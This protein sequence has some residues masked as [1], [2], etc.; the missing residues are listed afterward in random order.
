MTPILLLA[1]MLAQPAAKPLFNGKDLEGWARVNCAPGTFYVKDNQIITTGR[2]TGYLRSDKHYENFV[3]EFEWMHTK[4]SGVANSGMFVWGDA[5]PA[6]GVGY[7]RSIEV[8]VLCG[9]EDNFA[10]NNPGKRSWASDHGDLFSIW[11]AHCTP[12]RPHPDKIERCNPSENRSKGAGEWNHYKIT[13][14]DGVLKL[15]VNGKEV[16][17]VSKCTPRKGYIALES[18]GSECI[19]RNF[20]MEE[21]PSTNPKPEEIC[22]LAQGHETL[23]DGMTLD[24]WDAADGTW[25]SGDGSMKCVKDGVLKT[26]AALPAGEL[27]FDW[28]VGKEAKPEIM[29]TCGAET[30]KIATTAKGAGGY[31]RAQ[32]AIPAGTLAFPAL[33]DLELRSIFFKP[34]K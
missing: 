6:V 22:T 1:A 18:E 8:Q 4:K 28:K 13:A 30:V 31:C 24:G 23:F 10:K 15:A 20:K 17:G 5:L 33:K 14:N 26:K 34:A 25:K 11:G 32:V 27:I 29:L 7:T 16:S 9:F 19:F 12:D 3:L 21:L 2:P